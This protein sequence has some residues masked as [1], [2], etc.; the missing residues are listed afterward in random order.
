[1]IEILPIARA[2]LDGLY[3]QLAELLEVDETARA[4]TIATLDWFFFRNPAGDGVYAGA[5]ED[6]KLAGVA[7]ITPKPFLIARRPALA[8]ELGRAMT[9]AAF[10]GRGIFSRLVAYLVGEA[11]ERDYAFL[12]GTPNEASGRL[13]SKLGWTA[14]FH[15]DRSARPLLWTDHPML[16]LPARRAAPLMRPAWNIAFPLRSPR[17]MDCTVDPSP[18]AQAGRLLAADCALD[19]GGAYLQWRFARPG[20]TYHHLHCRRSDGELVGWAAASFVRD[21]DRRRMRIG[22]WWARPNALRG[23]LAGARDLAQ[24]LEATEIYAAGRRPGGPRIDRGY[25]FTVRPSRMP[26]VALPLHCGID[27]LA[28][29]DYREADADMF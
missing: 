11:R 18:D 6:G 8:G 21:G 3:P 20:G 10:R 7:S 1:L 4:A 15:W 24:E 13:Y 22:D 23:L 9:H 12:Y 5:F 19:R 25:G 29:W 28:R 14:L 17:W 27:E 2:E 16:P 26:V